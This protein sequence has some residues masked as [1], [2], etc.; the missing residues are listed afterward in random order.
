MEAK[1]CERH[2]TST[3]DCCKTGG[4]ACQPTAARATHCA[5]VQQY[6]ATRLL[7]DQKWP[8]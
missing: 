4:G 2:N 8:S 1:K 5:S 7:F 3:P 6:C